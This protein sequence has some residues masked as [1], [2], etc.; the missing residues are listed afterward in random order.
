MY[1][2]LKKFVKEEKKKGEG[3]DRLNGMSVKVNTKIH[4]KNYLLIFLAK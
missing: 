3:G 1:N 2:M 4:Y